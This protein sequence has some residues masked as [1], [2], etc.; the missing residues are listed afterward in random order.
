M[1]LDDD[2]E[3]LTRI[4]VFAAFEADALRKLA[5]AAETRLF[6]AGDLLFRRGEAS[7]GGLVLIAGSIA[8]DSHQDGRPAEKI[9]RPLALLGEAALAAPTTRAADAIARE[10]STVLKI[11]RDLF[12]RTLEQHPATAARVRAFF[13]SRLMD[14]AQELKLDKS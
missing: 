14:F 7:D 3:N 2:V 1:A 10:P 13:K 8:L 11:R 9:L 12:H 5:F 4:P 6:R